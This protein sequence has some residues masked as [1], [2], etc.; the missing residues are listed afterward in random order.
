MRKVCIQCCR[1]YASNVG[2]CDRDGQHLHSI[3][4]EY[5]HDAA[6]VVGRVLDGRY[7][8]DAMLGAGG[9]G[10]VLGAHHV[11]L[12]RRVAIKLLRPELLAF[13]SVRGRFFREARTASTISHPNVVEVIDFGVTRDD[14]CYLVME[15]LDGIDLGTRAR[16][17][18]PMP[19]AEVMQIGYEVARALAAIHAAGVVHR[20][21]KPENVS[22]MSGG[23]ADRIRLKVL[24]F[25]IA[26]IMAAPDGERLTKHGHAIGTPHY[27]S[28]E[29]CEGDAV[30]GRSDLYALGCIMWELAVGR[31]PFGGSTPLEILSA[32]ITKSAPLPSTLR[33]SLPLWFDEI[34]MKCLAK[35]ATD[36]WG[37]A[38]ELGA[39]IGHR[40]AR[41]SLTPSSGI[42]RPRPR[43]E[44]LSA[45]DQALPVAAMDAPTIPIDAE[46]MQQMITESAVTATPRVRLGNADPFLSR[47]VV[48]AYAL[49][50][51]N[52]SSVGL[53]SRSEAL[54]LG[55]VDAV[56][57][58]VFHWGG[59]YR[60]LGA[61]AEGRALV[62][63]AEAGESVGRL[64]NRLVRH[65]PETVTGKLGPKGVFEP[66]E[67]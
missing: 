50:S 31:P 54:A 57:E 51:T 10:I 21:L 55:G 61:E 5:G 49:P 34:V 43:E 23:S 1:E 44:L 41:S 18:G 3:L 62:E 9:M 46:Q 27:M 13:K 29:Q 15:Y 38:R 8:V 26:G 39:A 67:F 45:V 30:D 11:F 4:T 16:G 28:P 19:V 40:I 14:L 36:R 65:W 24:D 20:D 6:S 33:P 47:V 7:L 59:R 64:F 53:I 2:F 35:R 32:H 60:Y 37:S 48:N 17:Q 63:A 56:L 12:A 58:V 42:A 25:G 66:L 52:I 22:L